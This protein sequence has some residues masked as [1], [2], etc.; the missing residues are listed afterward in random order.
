MNQLKS[1]Q[2]LESLLQQAGEQNQTF[3][4][5]VLTIKDLLPIN[6]QYGHSLGNQV[7]QRY[8]RLLQAAFRNDVILGYWGHGEFIL[9]TV[10]LTQLEI[11]DRLG[12]IMAA[13]R[14][15]IFIA[16]NGDRF[17]ALYNYTVAEYP[18]DGK[19]VTFPLSD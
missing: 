8:G 17:S 19:N 6:R 14:K 2:E 11:R 5:V 18:T 7:L 3:C 15:Q 1:S 9:G 13:L 10:N 4:L 16:A 12:E